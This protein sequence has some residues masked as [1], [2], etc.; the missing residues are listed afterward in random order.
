M[1]LSY[2]DHDTITVLTVSG[3]LTSDQADAFRRASLDRFGA[4]V[5]DVVLD[6]EHMTL[7]DSAGL[8]ILLWL[9][10]EIRERGGRLRIVRPDETILKILHI[11]RLEGRF[12]IHEDI[13][14]AAMS[15]R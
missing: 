11:T 1:K 4:G 13:E 12:D 15:L 5:C 6:M 10:D 7:V 9:M 2:E 14:S 8:E 3:E